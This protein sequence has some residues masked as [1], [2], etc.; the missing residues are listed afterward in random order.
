MSKE[1]QVYPTYLAGRPE[2]ART[3][4]IMTGGIVTGGLPVSASPHSYPG[5]LKSRQD[6]FG[7]VAT[8]GL[9]F[10][11]PSPLRSLYRL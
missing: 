11:V 8:G 6:G 2:G 1:D 10:I 9:P 3:L 7:P 5:K 4:K